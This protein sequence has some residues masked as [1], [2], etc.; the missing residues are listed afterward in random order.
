MARLMW[1]PLGVGGAAHCLGPLHN[2]MFT[3]SCGGLKSS[4]LR[5]KLSFQ[6]ESF[7]VFV[8]SGASGASIT[9]STASEQ[10]ISACSS[11]HDLAVSYRQRR[12]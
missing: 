2:A 9:S 5:D 4:G 10:G 11:H 1:S 3:S 6:S 8:I 12:R 7:E